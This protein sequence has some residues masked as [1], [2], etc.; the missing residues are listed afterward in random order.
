MRGSSD[1]AIAQIARWP[2]GVF[3]FAEIIRNLELPAESRDIVS[4]KV[5]GLMPK[6]QDL[7][8]SAGAIARGTLLGSILGILP[9]GGASCATSPFVCPS[10]APSFR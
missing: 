1:S 10:A 9:G 3:G 7:I 2:L 4:A 5:T 6:R 8:D